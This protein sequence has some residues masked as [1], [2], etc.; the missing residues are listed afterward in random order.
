MSN[1]EII[2]NNLN[3]YR[4]DES[5]KKA[6][7]LLLMNLN[8]YEK[9]YLIGSRL[10]ST[11][12]G[13]DIDLM[14]VTKKVEYEYSEFL[15]NI[16][17]HSCNEKID[18]LLINENEISE[19]NEL[20]LKTITNFSKNL[21][22][23]E[24]DYPF[25]NINFSKI[26]HL[27]NIIDKSVNSIIKLEFAVNRIKEIDISKP[28]DEEEMILLDGE[29]ARFQRAYEKV[30]YFFKTYD[31][32]LKGE[33]SPTHRDL[34]L[35]MQKIGLIDNV[36]FWMNIRKTRNQIAHIYLEDF[37]ESTTKFTVKIMSNKLIELKDKLINIKNNLNK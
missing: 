36:E 1:Y 4:L 23:N 14:I 3:Q 19:S 20:F 22:S 13:G 10:D 35:N 11:K 25:Q 33:S 26:D 37:L 17:Q 28:I 15:K 32:F 21:I 18:I 2:Y 6:L 27:L 24:S 7:T 8:P 12:A 29:T 34:F 9:P 5:E 31:R 30:V 16:F